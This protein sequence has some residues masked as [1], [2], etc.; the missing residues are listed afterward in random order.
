M[1]G[2]RQEGIVRFSVLNRLLHLFVMVGFAGVA[3]TGF[4]LKFSDHNWAQLVVWIC[5]GAG[6]IRSFHRVFAVLT[7]GCVVVHLLW[8]VYFKAVLKGKITGA[9]S[10]F[11]R[12]KDFRDLVSHLTYMFGRGRSPL[13]GRF[14]YWEKFDY[15]AILIGM[16]TMGITGLVLW[17]PE[18]FTGFF[19][20]YFVNVAQ[21][22]HLYEAIMAVAL[23]FVVHIVTTHLRPEVFPLDKSIFNGRGGAERGRTANVGLML[24]AATLLW[25]VGVRE[26]KAVVAPLMPM[27][28]EGRTRVC[29]EC[30]RLPNVSTNEG[31]K[32]S[33]AFCLE[34]HGKDACVREDGTPLKVT[35]DSFGKGRHGHEACIKCHRDVSRS[36]HQSRSGALCSMCHNPHG[37]GVA[38]DPHLRLQCQA[39]HRKSPFIEYD[40]KRDLVVLSHKDDKDMPL[41]LVDHGLADSKDRDICN[42]CHKPGN[43]VGA[44]SAILPGK[45]LLCIV[46]HNA[47]IAVGHWVFGVAFLICVA[48]FAGM[49]LLWFR[50]RIGGEEASIHKKISVTGEAIWQTV[51]SSGFFRLL[52][53]FFFDVIMQR[54]LLKE[55]V[56]RWFSHALIYYGFL[57]KFFLSILSLV[58]FGLFPDS[59]TSIALLDKNNWLTAILNDLFG[60]LI[61]AGIVLSAVQR[62][63]VRPAHVL[64]EEQDSIALILIGFIVASGFILEGARINLTGVPA[65]KAVYSFIGYIVSG[66]LSSIMKEWQGAYGYIWWAHGIM[67]VIFFA[68]LPF[69]KLKHIVTTPLTLLVREGGR[70]E[71]I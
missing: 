24:L 41:S 32:S 65:D 56:R 66:F 17:F 18:F 39:C 58:A 51:F 12:L 44:S 46:C 55:S 13:F 57:G 53:V 35:L 52:S 6:G 31:A 22:L 15:W 64:S 7:Y 23:K 30:H 37:E 71:R 26:A 11:P 27:T 63:L 43:T 59:H 61:L 9:D 10:L 33:Q 29:L 5:G 48:G 49:V 36:P 21:V 14:S 69:G 1:T 19:P 54:R 2:Q 68:Y 45:S 38:G 47:P 25:G 62:F 28:E 60:G 50:G 40:I 20:G 3:I 34:C 70:L 8:L 67:W 4:S 42:R 16:N